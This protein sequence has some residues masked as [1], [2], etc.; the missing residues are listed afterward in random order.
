MSKEEFIAKTEDIFREQIKKTTTDCASS[1]THA[2]LPSDLQYCDV[3]YQTGYKQAQNDFAAMLNAMAANIQ[4]S[5]NNVQDE[6]VRDINMRSKSRMNNGVIASVYGYTTAALLAMTVALRIGHPHQP[7]FS[8]AFASAVLL[9]IW[10][11]VTCIKETRK[12][13]P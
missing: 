4:I 2:T 6:S 7:L 13:N 12:Y 5:R 1:I 10:G 9:A 11:T 8:I 3:V